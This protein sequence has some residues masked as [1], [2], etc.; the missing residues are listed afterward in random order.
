MSPPQSVY[1]LRHGESAF[2]AV[3]DVT[4]VDPGIIDARLTERGREQVRALSETVRRLGCELVVTSPLTRAIETALGLFDGPAAPPIVVAAL[5]RERLGDAC[6]IGRPPSA[7]AREF[8]M[9]DFRHLPETW[10]HT[11]ELDARGVPIESHEQAKDRIVEFRAWLAGR[12]EQSILLV[13]HAGF[14]YRLGGVDLANAELS[15]LSAERW[16]ANI[17]AMRVG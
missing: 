1:L 8:P 13:G 4:G 17:P 14:L 12:T 9:L 3:Y 7:L 10:W 11:G 6:D 2:N 16:T 15:R 5:M